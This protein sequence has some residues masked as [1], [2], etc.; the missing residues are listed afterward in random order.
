MQQGQDRRQRV[1]GEQLLPAQND[2][3]KSDC[4]AQ[5]CD[6]PPDRFIGKKG[7]ELA[8][9]DERQSDGKPGRQAGQ[10]DRPP[11][12]LELAFSLSPDGLV[13]QRS[14]GP[15]LRLDL[16]RLLFRQPVQPGGRIECRAAGLAVHV[17]LLFRTPP[18]ARL[19]PPLLW[20]R[21]TP[22]NVP[23]PSTVLATFVFP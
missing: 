21:A 3:Q 16:F 8:L 13:D 1:L 22:T 5:W 12:P 19:A 2:N 10:Y 14:I 11:A 20:R 23:D 18:A 17:K 9:N 7:L 4:V 6:Q 15:A